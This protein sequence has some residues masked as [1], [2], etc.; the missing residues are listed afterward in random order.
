MAIA[1]TLFDNILQNNVCEFKWVRR[2]PK[3]GANFTR[4]ALG[5]ANMDVL[6]SEIGRG[7]FGFQVPRFQ[8]PYSRSQYNLCGYYDIFRLD[9][10]NA[11]CE[12]VVM[13]KVFPATNPTAINEWWKTFKD[14]VLPLNAQQ[15]IQ[16][17]DS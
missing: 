8:H 14:D 6:N 7:V 3:T 10:R 16:F 13:V 15:K 17:M 2:N 1:K 9:W 5:T 12:S 11:A 4:R